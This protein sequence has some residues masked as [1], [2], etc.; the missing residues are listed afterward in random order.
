MTV[1]NFLQESPYPHRVILAL[2]EGKIPYDTIGFELLNKPD[3]FSKKVNPTTA[4]VL[5]LH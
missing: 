2:E 5:S 4:K 1:L 3:W